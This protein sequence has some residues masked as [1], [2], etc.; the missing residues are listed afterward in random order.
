MTQTTPT[1]AMVERL[2][3]R[4]V[5]MLGIEM[6][7][8]GELLDRAADLIESLS[9][10]QDQMPTIWEDPA[11]KGY[12][13]F[14]RPMTPAECRDTI[15]RYQAEIASLSARAGVEDRAFPEAG[16][17]R[18]LLPMQVELWAAGLD[19]DTA[20]FVA[21]MLMQ[22][23]Y[24]LIGPE[25]PTRHSAGEDQFAENA[26]CSNG[27]P[28]GADREAEIER[29]ARTLCRLDNEIGTDAAKLSEYIDKYWREWVESAETVLA[30]LKG[31]AL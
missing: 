9:A 14:E 31:E 27:R 30:S 2:R 13:C 26:I 8:T 17:G 24:R 25:E 10:A 7:D 29:V 4:A 6:K 1:Q 11:G 12:P 20:R 3:N 5:S 22:Q 21:R 28:G 16:D 19:H 15:E 23:G 18:D